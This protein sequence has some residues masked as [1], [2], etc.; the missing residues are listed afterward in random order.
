M[1]HFTNYHDDDLEEI[2]QLFYE[3]V[4]SVNA[5]DYSQAQLEAWAPLAIQPVKVA[6]WQK[7][8]RHNKTYVARKHHQIVGFGDMTMEGYLDRLYVHKDF[9]GQGIASAIVDLLEAD[10]KKL[11][12]T[13]I[14]TDASLTARP[15]FERKGYQIMQTQTVERQGISLTNVSMVKLLPDEKDG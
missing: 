5:K 7:T 14:Y 10:A 13:H 2:L 6:T 9:Q 12:L 11:G 3:T 1:L 8:L 4:H 15:F